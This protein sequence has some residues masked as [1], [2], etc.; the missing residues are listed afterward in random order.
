MFV[1]FAVCV[2]GA[3]HVFTRRCR[4]VCRWMKFLRIEFVESKVSRLGLLES[5]ALRFHCAC[6]RLRTTSFLL[7]FDNVDCVCICPDFIVIF[8]LWIDKV[9]F[10][11]YNILG[12]ENATKHQ[13]LYA[14]V[15]PRF[16][17]WR[18]RKKLIREELKLYDADIV[19]FQASSLFASLSG[20]CVEITRS[21]DL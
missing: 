12:V 16:L 18:R 4:F 7:L 9:V 5:S 15:Q 6:L 8:I 20:F 10:V 14:E 1:F 2:F 19:C 21:C 11:S 13:D 17:K 3:E